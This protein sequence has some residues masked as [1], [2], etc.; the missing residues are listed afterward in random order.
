MN[1]LFACYYMKLEKDVKKC[2]CNKS[3]KHEFRRTH[4]YLLDGVIV[5]N[6][7]CQNCD[8]FLDKNNY[9]SVGFL[10]QMT[11]YAKG[12]RY[13]VFSLEDVLESY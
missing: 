1:I 13:A 11:P 9:Y 4:E 10:N 7:D 5:T 6:K 2:H 12:T 8:Y 3:H